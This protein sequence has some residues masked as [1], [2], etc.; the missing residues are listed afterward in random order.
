[1]LSSL[2][3]LVPGRCNVE[4][5]ACRARPL[6]PLLRCARAIAAALP[7]SLLRHFYACTVPLFVRL[8]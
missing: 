4:K 3:R 8:C 5:R 1:M 7:V 6:E 2:A